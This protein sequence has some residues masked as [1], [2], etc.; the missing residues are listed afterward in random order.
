MVGWPMPHQVGDL[1]FQFFAMLAGYCQR[2]VE[3]IGDHPAQSAIGG[4]IVAFVFFAV[5]ARA[6]CV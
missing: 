1:L 6:K 5:H 4:F 2:F 3:C